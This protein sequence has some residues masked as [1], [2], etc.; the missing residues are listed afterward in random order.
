MAR[1]CSQVLTLVTLL[2][3]LDNSCAYFCSNS[4]SICRKQEREALLQ[5]RQSISD[6]FGLLSSWKGKDCCRWDGVICDGVTSHVIKLQLLPQP[7]RDETSVLFLK[8]P[9]LF[10]VGELNSSLLHLIYLNHLDLSGINSN[11]GRIPEVISSMKQLR[12][13]NLSFANFYG[14]VP[15]QLGNLT[16]LEVLDLH[17]KD[18]NLVVD[19]I[20]WISYLRSLK[21]LDMSGSM[22]VNKRV[23]MKVISTLPALSH[24]SLS[25]CGFHNFHFSSCHLTNSTSLVHLQY[26]DLSSNLLEGTIPSTLFQNMT[27]LHHLDLSQNIFNSSIPMWFDKFTSLVHLNL[28]RN[29][30]DSF[31]GG[32]FSFLKNMQYLKSLHLCANQIGEE[33]SITQGNSSGLIKSSLETLEICSN[34]L[35]GALPD[36]LEHF[37]NLET[38]DLFHNQL[39]GHIPESLGKLGALQHLDLGYNHLEGVITEI[40]FSNLPR[41]KKLYVD[42]NNNLS[43]KA[44][45]SWIPPFQLVIIWMDSLKFSTKFPRWIMTQVEAKYIS[46]ANA[47]LFGPLPKWLANSTFSNLDLSHN[48]ITGPLPEWSANLT[49]SILDLSHN[50]IT[51]PLPEWSAN[52]TFSILDLSHNHI[53]G[54][55]PEWSANLTFSNLDLSSNQ[56]TGPLPEWSANLTFSNLDLSCNQITGPLPEWLANFTI[57]GFNLSCNKIIGPLPQWSANLTFSWLDLSYNQITGPFPNMSIKCTYLDLSNNLISGSLPIDIGIMYQVSTLYLNDNLIDGTLPSSLCDMELFDLNL[58]NNSLFGSIP[59]YWK[60]SL[61]FLTLSF[62]KLSGVIPSSLGSLLHLTTLHLNGNRLNGE[63]PQALD[64]CTRLVILDLGENNF[65]GIIPT[66]FDESFQSLL[67]LRL[68]ENS[69]IGSIPPQLC[70]LSRLKILD[71]AMNNLMGTIPHCLG[72]MSNMIK[73]NQSNPFGSVAIAPIQDIISFRYGGYDP[74]WNREH[75]VEILKGRYNEYT[76]IVLQLVVNLDLSSNFLNGSI[77]KELSFLSGMHGLNLSH[78]HLS[79]NIPIGIGNMT[80]LESLDLSNNH[81]SGTIPQGISVLTSLAHLN[82]SHNNFTGTIPKGNQ[83]QTLDDPSIYASNP[84][85]CGDLL[86]KKCLGVESPQQSKIPHLEDTHEKDRLDKALFY[87]VVIF[88]FATGFWGFFGVLQFKKDWRH[89]YFSFANHVANKTYVVIVVKVAKLKRLRLS[90]SV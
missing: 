8:E 39:E 24:L 80:S 28:E 17:G 65:S 33:I 50:Q 32:L 16:K 67:I 5:L 56:I 86:R 70:S 12:Y 34:H 72:N 22:I 54:P 76:K 40:H 11:H 4:T 1:Y 36:W 9:K 18:E 78:N 10:L 83:I 58:A 31:E 19:D 49:F 74:Q 61:T 48:Q 79:G 13:L 25:G 46:L 23:F 21:Y 63:L 44:K 89:A 88:G 82:L 62:N 85:L 71:M 38:L 69:F 75:V 27:S 2:L 30:F 47:S 73:F 6:P 68:R 14:M 7:R 52:L 64:Y 53:I 29:A 55:L 15:R 84:L 87:A 26:L 37:T 35:K 60:G 77:P 57:Q 81:L 66:W 51:G 59:N 43:F 20:L 45:P 42:C 41:L 3:I 90:R